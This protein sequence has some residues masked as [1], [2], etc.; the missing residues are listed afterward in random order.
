[1][2]T[3][4][5]IISL[6]VTASAALAL[7]V[8]VGNPVEINPPYIHS[9]ARLEFNSETGKYYQVQINGD[10]NGG[11]W[12]NEGYSVKG[13]GGTQSILVSTRNYD[14]AFFMIL[15][16]GDPANTAPTGPEGP[17]GQEGPQG[18]PGINGTNGV[19]GAVGP[20]G[21]QGAP[22]T[23]APTYTADLPFTISTNYVIGLNPASLDGDVLTYSASSNHW[24]AARPSNLS[25]IPDNLDNRQP[26]NTI[27]LCIALYGVFPSRSSADPLLGEIAMFGFNFT[28]R[29][30]A[31]CNGQLMAI[32]QNSALFSLLGTQY[33][34]DGRTTFALPDMRGRVPIH[35]GNGPGL[36]PYPNQ[37]TRGGSE[38]IPTHRH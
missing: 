32:S 5:A 15:D 2:K 25:V 33:G 28:P 35:V 6:F 19:D 21:P 20:A 29:N 10:L 37:G 4:L 14:P 24:I 3:L 23:P 27:R 8:T 7:E 22:A 36:T 16:G 38:L 34:G 17:M 31:D 11:I 30:W 26:Y 18:L 9:A 12:D 13:N 1:M